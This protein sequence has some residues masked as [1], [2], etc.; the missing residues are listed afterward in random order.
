[1]GREPDDRGERIAVPAVG[2]VEGAPWSVAIDG[3]HEFMP[4]RARMKFFHPSESEGS[5]KN[6]AVGLQ[7]RWKD[8]R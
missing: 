5:Q 2:P 6:G 8:S 3:A 4:G 1:M 7:R